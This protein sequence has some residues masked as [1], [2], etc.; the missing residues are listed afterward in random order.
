MAAVASRLIL[1]MLALVLGLAVAAC[2]PSPSPSPP[3][4]AATA[5][6]VGFEATADAPLSPRY[7]AGAFWTGSEV[8]VIGGRDDEPCPPNADCARPADAGLSDG[9]AYTPAIDRWRGISPAPVPL[10]RPLGV[11]VVQTL[12]VLDRERGFLAYDLAAD[13]WTRLAPPDVPGSVSGLV[14]LG[15][16]VVAVRGSDENGPLADAIYDPA[17]AVW[18]PL[19]DDP[20]GPS[21]DRTMVATP[22][23]L[24]LTA[25]PLVEQPGSAEPSLYRAASLD[26]ATLAW[27][28]LPDSEVV[29]G[30]PLW[31]WAGGLVVNADLGSADGGAV[32]GWGRSYPFGGMLDPA[33]GAWGVLPDAPVRTGPLQGYSATGDPWALSSAGVVL[34]VPSRSW[35]PVPAPPNAPDG[36]AAVTWAADRLFLW[37]GVSWNAGA[38][39]LL[40]VGWVW[41]PEAR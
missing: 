35:Q 28:R 31:G 41:S 26:G 16:K 22:D 15:D 24:V 23:G 40:G 32:N 3:A 18:A 4:S 25:V 37:G 21:F 11:V 38:G 13:A 5:A 34:H 2:A 7:D 8:L 19:P 10:V 6:P 27:S 12:F 36:T 9:A 39:M 14:G 33:T 1:L 17:S 20:L 30:A 29:A